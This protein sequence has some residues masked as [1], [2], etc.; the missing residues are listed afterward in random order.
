M[1]VFVI[2][3]DGKRRSLK[4]TGKAVVSDVVSKTKLNPEAVLVR[5]GKEIITFDEPV[6]ENDMLEI[7]NVASGG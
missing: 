1:N 4:L 3:P 5:R 7:I 6:S 2:M